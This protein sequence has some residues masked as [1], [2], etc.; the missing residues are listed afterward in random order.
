MNL[1]EAEHATTTYG[2]QLLKTRT[3]NL[4]EGPPVGGLAIGS[5]V[6]ADIEKEPEGEFRKAP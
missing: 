1:P 4:Y 5:A 2:D 6:R 3:T